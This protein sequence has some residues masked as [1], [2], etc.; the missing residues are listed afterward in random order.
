MRK[1]ALIGAT[2][3]IGN[4]IANAL[5]SQGEAYRAVGRNRAA[6][7]NGF[8]KDPLAEIVT[9][10]PDNP[11][12]VRTACSGVD[13][14]IYLV[15]VPYNR[16]EL[17]PVLMGK[18]L[19]GAVAEAVKRVVLIGTVYPYGRPQTTKVTEEHPREPHTYKGKMRKDR[20][21]VV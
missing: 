10:D 8:G 1:A 4:S 3:A 14:L 5:R 20:K 13:T 7:E 12:S 6:L 11:A 9:W 15:G 19:N 16:F 17:H 2:G 18:M 21:S